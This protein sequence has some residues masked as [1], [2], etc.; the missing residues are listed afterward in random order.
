MEIQAAEI[1]VSLSI[2]KR[3]S[4]C[5]TRTT[6]LWRWIDDKRMCNACGIYMKKH[7]RLRTI[8]RSGVY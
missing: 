8:C 2:R 3:C 4:H 1:L 5:H 6:P 7:N